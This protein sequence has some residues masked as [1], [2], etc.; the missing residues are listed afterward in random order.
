MAGKREYGDYQTP[1]EFTDRI[2]HLLV[3]K[4]HLHPTT[5]I[6]PTC[7]VGNFLKSALVFNALKYYGIEINKDYCEQCIS[8]INDKRLKVI[9]TNIFGF[10]IKDLIDENTLILGNPP[11]VNNSTLATLSSSNLPPKSNISGLK[12]LEAK[13]GASN[14][15]IC[16]YIIHNLIEGC[17]D[18]DTTIAMLTKTSVAVK[19][20]KELKRE[21]INFKFIDEITF[22]ARQIF[23]IWA[24][25]CLLVIQLSKEESSSDHCDVYSLDDPNT[26]ISRYGYKNNKFYGNLL[27]T[28]ESFD[29]ECP[30]VWR[31][32]IK[33]DLSQVMELTYANGSYINGYGLKVDIEPEAI[34]PLVKT[35]SIVSPII[36]TFDKYVIVTQKR[37]GEDT[38]NLS[39]TL[40]KTWKY[41]NRY[42]QEFNNRKSSIYK[43]ANPFAIFGVGDYSFSPYKV[44]VSGFHKEP[45]FSVVHSNDKPVMCDDTCYFISI[46]NE[47]D[48]Y[49]I[50]LY[51]N[52]YRVKNFIKSL[53]FT[54][55]KRPYTKKI[56]ERIDLSKIYQEITLDE[57]KETEK[58][59]GLNPRINKQMIERLIS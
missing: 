35:T 27:I 28:D 1:N 6:E 31:Q 36:N 42:K 46:D 54:N 25:A 41:L 47:D 34:Y 50:M 14:F 48:A 57:L 23:G 17:K 26:L 56:L 33:H 21:K 24:S 30:Y 53:C 4:Y 39:E 18:S 2:C 43:P 55:E 51:L 44:V 58:N 29:G 38:L 59:L 15:D 10:D 8:N 52:S 5:I 7:G 19:I 13:M 9:N 45:L 32:G 22:N 20:F 11:W 37:V 16:E 49:A 40:P 12:G 3:T